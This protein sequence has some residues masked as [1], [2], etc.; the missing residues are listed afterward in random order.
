MA[1][2]Y[3]ASSYTVEP[4]FLIDCTVLVQEALSVLGIFV[5]GAASGKEALT[6]KKSQH[7]DSGISL[8]AE[9]ACCNGVQHIVVV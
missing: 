1:F 2:K 7:A 9:A 8:E 3:S 6:R 5:K 4:W